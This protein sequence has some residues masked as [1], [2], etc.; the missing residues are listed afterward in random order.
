MK[1]VALR[2]VRGASFLAAILAAAPDFD[3]RANLGKASMFRCRTD[4]FRQFIVVDVRSLAAGVADQ[5]NT[6]MQAAGVLVSDIGVGAFHP[7]GEI[8]PD[9]QVEDPVDAV[10][11]NPLAA[12]FRHRFGNVISARGP[13]EA[14][15]RI[16]HRRAHVGPLLT[17]LD[18]STSGC[19]AQ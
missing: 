2:L 10:G 18:N 3:H 19:V 7:T 15:Q 6:V 8:C 16:E 13:V 4:A 5:E 12:S 14:C 11:R 9:E 17:A 1:D